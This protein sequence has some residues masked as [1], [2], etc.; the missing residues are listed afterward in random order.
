ML[1]D[2]NMVVNYNKLYH[3]EQNKNKNRINTKYNDNANK[4]LIHY[5]NSNGYD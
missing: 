4:R 3:K 1:G 2:S 5:R